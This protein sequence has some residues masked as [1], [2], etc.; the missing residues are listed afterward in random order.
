MLNVLTEKQIE[1]TLPKPVGS[2]AEIKRMEAWLDERVAKGKKTPFS[3]VV[4]LTPVLASLLLGRNTNNRNIMRMNGEA[5]RNDILAGRWMFN[6]ES[7]VISDTGILLDGQHRC[8]A[9]TQTGMSIP[10]SLVFGAE[11][12][13]RFT[14]DIGSPKSAANFLHMKGYKDCNNMAAAIA[15][16]I[17]YQKSGDIPKGYSRPTKTEIVQSV[18]ELKGIQASIDFVSGARIL[19]SRST[20][21]FCHYIF[22]KRSGA[23]VADDF[24]GRLIDGSGLRKGD[25]IYHC[26]ERLIAMKGN[27]YVGDRARVIFRTWNHWRQG[28]TITKVIAPSKLPKLER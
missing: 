9:V 8:D 24:M 21:A 20:L 26:R 11:E 6:G 15:L 3:E 22:K 16:V 2:P 1:E 18:G 7:I 17:Q 13:A 10:V 25:P 19:G 4:T 28:D 5:I 12:E 23:V 14:I 27:S